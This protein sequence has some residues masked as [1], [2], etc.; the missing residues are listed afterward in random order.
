[1]AD[2]EAGWVACSLCSEPV[3][4]ADPDTWRQVTVWVGGPKANG[5]TLQGT[6]VLAFAHGSCVR[7]ARCGISPTQGALL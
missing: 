7:L 6:E 3:R 5:A 4:A 1:M 2:L